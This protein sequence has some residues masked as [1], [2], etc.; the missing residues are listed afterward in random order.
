M[1]F[2]STPIALIH[3]VIGA[4]DEVIMPVPLLDQYLQHFYP[5]SGYIFLEVPFDVATH[6]KIDTYTCTQQARI[7]ALTQHLGCTGHVFAFF[8][9]HSEQDSGWLFAG[10]VNGNFVAMSV[11]QVCMHVFSLFFANF[12]I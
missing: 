5:N 6:E 1:L 10:K 3:F 2:T 12:I 8:S 11:S 4:H 7:A 9:N